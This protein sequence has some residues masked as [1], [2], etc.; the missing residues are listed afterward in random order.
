MFR[1]HGLED[2]ADPERTH[3]IHN[4]GD[5]ILREQTDDSIIAAHGL[6]ERIPVRAMYD[7]VLHWEMILRELAGR[8]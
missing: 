5:H 6:D 7:D 4:G 2:G 1:S 3:V 8:N